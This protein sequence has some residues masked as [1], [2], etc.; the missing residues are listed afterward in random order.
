MEAA[1]DAGA[2][3]V[4][5]NTRDLRTI[6]TDLAVTDRLAGMVPSGKIVVSES[7]VSSRSHVDR[8]GRAGAHA[9]LVGEAL[10]AAEDVA[11]KLRELI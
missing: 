6:V 5:I 4:G 10:V 3:T 9:V 1:L 7:G 8:V 2:D 11:A